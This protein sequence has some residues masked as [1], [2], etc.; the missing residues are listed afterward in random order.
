MSTKK[1]TRDWRNTFFSA[2]LFTLVQSLNS[3][4]VLPTS[5]TQHATK[6]TNQ[7]NEMG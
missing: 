2:S 1:V 3:L 6:I 4:P 7:N 5:V